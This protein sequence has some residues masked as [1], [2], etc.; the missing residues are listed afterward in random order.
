MGYSSALHI[1]EQSSSTDSVTSGYY[2]SNLTDMHLNNNIL[3][4]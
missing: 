2:L 3:L 1:A 4:K